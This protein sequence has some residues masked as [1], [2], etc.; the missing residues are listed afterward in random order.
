MTV[1][2]HNKRKLNNAGAS[3]IE[4]LVIMAILAVLL[5]GTIIGFSVV[6]SSNVKQASRTTKTFMEKTR[7]SSMSVLA[8]EWGFILERT[9]S[10]YKVSV[11]KTY[12]K[13]GVPVTETLDEKVLGSRISATVISGTNEYALNDG[14]DLKVVFDKS[15]GE[16]SKVTFSGSAC[17]PADNMISINYTSG[18]NKSTTQLYFISGKI[19]IQ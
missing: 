1:Q 7:S 6:N 16:V 17:T 19:E 15:S 2:E 9:G 3:L 4:L 5:S 18:K 11:Y 10:E 13:D 8:D 12:K 14:D